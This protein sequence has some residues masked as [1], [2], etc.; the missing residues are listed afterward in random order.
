MGLVEESRSSCAILK[1]RRHAARSVRPRGGMLR[2]YD[3]ASSLLSVAIAKAF[4]TALA[5]RSKDR[6]EL[7]GVPL[8]LE[9]RIAALPCRGGENVLRQLFEPLGYVVE[10]EQLP[11]DARPA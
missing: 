3:A 1:V 8:S 2:R 4:G 11:F 7:A 5:G 6:P 10:A 9:V